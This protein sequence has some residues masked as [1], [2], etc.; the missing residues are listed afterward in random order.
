MAAARRTGSK[1]L[2]LRAAVSLCRLLR[3]SGRGTEAKALLEPLCA[4]LDTGCESV[5]WTEARSLLG[6]CP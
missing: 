3:E 6:S 4:T 5:D 2:E 1:G